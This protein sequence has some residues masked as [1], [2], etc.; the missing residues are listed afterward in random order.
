MHA[1]VTAFMV[2]LV[3]TG[4]H[5]VPTRVEIIDI[6]LSATVLVRNVRFLFTTL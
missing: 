5:F 2:H 3:D 6:S 1:G 4:T